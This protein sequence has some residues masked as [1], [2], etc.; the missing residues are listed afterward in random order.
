MWR[1]I[2]R[3]WLLRYTLV[4]CKHSDL[5]LIRYCGPE[6]CAGD[7]HH[8]ACRPSVARL[9]VSQLRDS[10]LQQPVAAMRQ[11]RIRAFLIRR[12]QTRLLH[13]S[14]VTEAM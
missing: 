11:R 2:G 14:F 3:N 5:V 13:K 9:D 4:T 12:Q 8:P 7:E 1:A 6:R 10:D